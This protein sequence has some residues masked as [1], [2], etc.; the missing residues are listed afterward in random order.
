MIIMIMSKIMMTIIMTTSRWAFPKVGLFSSSGSGTPT[1]LSTP[2]FMQVRDGNF[3]NCGGKCIHA[4]GKNIHICGPWEI[5]G[6]KIFIFMQILICSS[7]KYWFAQVRNNHSLIKT[8]I[9]E[10]WEKIKSAPSKKQINI[11]LHSEFGHLL[12]DIW[13][14][15]C[16]L[17]Y[18]TTF[19]I[20]FL[21]GNAIR[22]PHFCQ[23][24]K[25]KQSHLCQNLKKK[26]NSTFV[27]IVGNVDIVD[28]VVI[29]ETI[30]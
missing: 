6:Q 2:S 16:S 7:R 21:A 8:L 20:S 22:R 11:L 25:K 15:G 4:N 5:F 19:P 13:C 26:T 27:D 1:L 12:L 23:N 24:L 17:Q 3:V 14:K 30:Y 9:F 18:Y 10:I 28:T 29:V